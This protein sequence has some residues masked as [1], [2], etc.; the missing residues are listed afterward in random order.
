MDWVGLGSANIAR[1]LVWV[2]GLGSAS[3]AANWVKSAAVVVVVW[4]WHP[5][6]DVRS[7]A[8]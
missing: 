2:W 1:V 6:S 8:G 4:W 7:Q 5:L 3:G